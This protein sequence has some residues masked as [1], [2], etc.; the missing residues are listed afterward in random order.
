MPLKTPKGTLDYDPDMMERLQRIINVIRQNALNQGAQ[1]IDTP[2]MEL[3]SLLLDKYGEEA[4]TKLIYRL[5]K[6]GHEDLSLR[7]DLTVP[8]QRYLAIRG[9]ESMKRFQV[10][11]VY[12]KDQPNP[13]RGRFREFI[14]A[15]LDIVGEEEPMIPEAQIM[16]LITL[17]LKQLGLTNYIIRINFRDNL[18]AMIKRA[19]IDEKL[20]KDVCISIDKLDK[21]PW[22]YVATE[23][24]ERGLTDESIASLKTD[25]DG[26]YQDESIRNDLELLTKYGGFFN[27][28][29]KIRFD[30]SLAR[31]LDYY[32]G[33]I[34]EVVLELDESEAKPEIDDDE[35]ENKNPTL[36]A[37]GRYDKLIKFRNKK[38]LPAIGVSFGVN[39]LELALR[40]MLPPVIPFRIFVVSQPSEQNW[41]LDVVNQLLDN[42]YQ[43]EFFAG[44]KKNVKQ[45]NQAIKENYQYILILGEDGTQIKVKSNDQEPDQLIDFD[46]EGLVYDKLFEIFKKDP[47][48]QSE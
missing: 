40:E 44:K 25:L 13:S 39:R 26:N 46:D 32:T 5:E 4:E 21:K 22:S 45:I 36:I 41:K 10:G 18:F 34:Y 24:K 9:L 17:S 16:K 43:V 2:S 35:D 29:E 12:R 7:Y 31:G 8:L 48:E 27:Y 20:F 6:L 15:D 37:G 1:E 23:L 33:L 3:T 42:G 14:Q 38:F 19:K 47:L 28:I 30:S 11:K